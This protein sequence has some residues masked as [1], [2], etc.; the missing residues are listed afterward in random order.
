MQDVVC[1]RDRLVPAFAGIEVGF[2]KFYRR[3]LGADLADASA[4]LLRFCEVS[5]RRAN[6]PA[7]LQQLCDA[8]NSDIAGP[9]SDKNKSR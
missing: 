6:A 9:A 7:L 2:N 1:T 8:E 5:Y 3:R 4:H